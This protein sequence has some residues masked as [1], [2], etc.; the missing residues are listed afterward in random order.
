MRRRLPLGRIFSFLVPV[1]FASALVA[2]LAAA[3][4]TA[5]IQV[6]AK[7]APIDRG[8]LQKETQLTS[9]FTAAERAKLP[10]AG[11]ELIARLDARPAP[12]TKPKTVDAHATETTSAVLGAM[13]GQDVES[14]VFLVLMHAWKAT[15]EDL[16]NVAAAVKA[17]NAAKAALGGQMTEQHK[18]DAAAEKALFET[19][20]TRL[21]TQSYE[22][23]ADENSLKWQAFI[24]RQAKIAQTVTNTMKKWADASANISQNVK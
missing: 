7:I 12:N 5:T 9:R 24:E 18:A 17:L 13:P 10:A 4:G 3:D 1:V 15:N 6:P 8:A 14:L 11:K 20:K 22:A 2:A 21:K 16:K 19:Y 23:L